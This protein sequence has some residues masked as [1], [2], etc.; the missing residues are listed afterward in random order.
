MKV[1]REK[2]INYFHTP[3]MEGDRMDLSIIVPV[4]K[5]E[6][7]L[8][9]CVKSLMVQ[10]CENYE[11]ILIDDGSPD[12]CPKICDALASSAD[13]IRVIHKTN[14]GLSSARNAGLAIARGEYIGFVDSDDAAAPDMFAIM[15][16]AA[17]ASKADIVMCDYIR[18]LRTG[19]QRLMTTCLHPGLYEKADIM[20]YLYPSLIMGEH[21]DYG[22]LLSV[23]HCLYNR[24]FLRQYHLT[25]AQD[26]PWSEDNLFNAMAGY[27]AERFFYLKS[28]GLYYYFQNPETITTSRRPGAW[29]VYKRMN[30][31]LNNY[32]SFR[33]DYD[34]KRQ[35]QLHLLYYACHVIRMDS[36]KSCIQSVLKDL[37]QSHLFEH[38]KMPDVS[39]KLKIQLWLMKHQCVR[40]LTFLL[41]GSSC[42]WYL[43][44]CRSITRKNTFPKYWKP[45]FPS[46][47]KIGK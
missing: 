15:M 11:I 26:I 14:G 19:E 3:E 30:Q 29:N 25:F 35:L 45:S 8:Q 20:K 18:I 22:P 23:W 37:H 47:F 34:F 7:Y 27:H 40:T 42:R 5:V 36:Q 17:K 9:R 28:M 2:L 10:S 21:L 31:Y 24:E 6:K 39:L 43:L 44:S 32:F 13:N 46:L 1:K 41:E 4:Y 12:N 16:S 33:S 38:F